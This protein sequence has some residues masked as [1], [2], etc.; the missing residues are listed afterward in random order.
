MSPFR[1]LL[2]ALP[3]SL[4]I[5]SIGQSQV[6]LLGIGDSRRGCPVRQ[7]LFC[8]SQPNTY[9]KRVATQMDVPFSQPLLSTSATAFVFTDKGRARLYPTTDPADLAVSGATSGDIINSVAVTGTPTTEY[10][11]VLPPYYGLS[12]LQIVEQLK[13][14]VVLSL[15]GQRRPDQ[16]GPRLLESQQPVAHA[17]TR[18]HLEL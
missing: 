17:V 3:L 11:L 7:R 1:S 15:G 8:Q 2:L 14:K 18:V 9:L 12:Q 5:Q 16:P 6:P 13:P 10:D 4:A